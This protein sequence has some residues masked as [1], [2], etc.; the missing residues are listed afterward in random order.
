MISGVLNKYECNN[1]IEFCED[2]HKKNVGPNNVCSLKLDTKFPSS[3]KIFRNVNP[4]IIEK[5]LGYFF[6]NRK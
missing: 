4:K 5:N 1:I 3:E 2:K 6:M